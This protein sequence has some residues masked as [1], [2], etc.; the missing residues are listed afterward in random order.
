MARIIVLTTAC[1][2]ALVAPAEAECYTTFPSVIHS[3]SLYVL[4]NSSRCTCYVYAGVREIQPAPAI[5]A[6]PLKALWLWRK[7]LCFE[8]AFQVFKRVQRRSQ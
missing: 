4:C 6:N 3:S 5:S 7:R 2:G 1:S 8:L